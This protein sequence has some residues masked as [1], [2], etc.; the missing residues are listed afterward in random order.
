M[1]SLVFPVTVFINCRFVFA[2]VLEEEKHYC[3]EYIQISIIL[4]FI[5]FQVSSCVIRGNDG[6]G[7]F[8]TCVQQGLFFHVEAVITLS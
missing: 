5:C 1:L 8:H 3:N 6:E 2:W 7:S 4:L